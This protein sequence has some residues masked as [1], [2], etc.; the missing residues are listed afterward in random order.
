MTPLSK[1]TCNVILPFDTYRT[2]LNTS[3]ETVDIE[4]EMKFFKAAGE[5]LAEIWSEVI[6]DDHL[7]KVTYIDPQERS[8]GTTKSD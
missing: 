3:N 2:H 7:V 1:G 4:L 5:I 6:I 8:I